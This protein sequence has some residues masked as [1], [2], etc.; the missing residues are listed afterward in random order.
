M[1]F[2]RT[3]GEMS[4]PMLAPSE[5]RRGLVLGGFIV[6]TAGLLWIPQLTSDLW[7]DETGTYWMIKGGIARAFDLGARYQNAQP[8]FYVVEWLDRVLIGSSEAAL[9]MP[10]LLAAIATAALVFALGRR[11]FDRE[12]GLLAA[13]AFV[14][15]RQIAFAAGDARPY[16]LAILAVVASILFLDRWI[17]RRSIRDAIGFLVA[18]SIMLHLHYLYAVILPIHAGY[19]LLRGVK[20][21]NL[22]VGTI[23]LAILFLPAVPGFIF[24]ASRRNTLASPVSAQLDALVLV[25]L[26]IAI[27]VAAVV[28]LRSDSVSDP[29]IRSGWI[30]VSVW[31]LLPPLVLLIVSRTTS[32]YLYEARYAA[33]SLPG[34]ALLI[35]YGFRLITKPAIRFLAACLILITSLVTY[36]FN[37]DHWVEPWSKVQM[38]VNTIAESQ[39]VVLVRTG[40]VE[41]SQIDWLQGGER[42]DYVSA[43]LSY[44]PFRGSVV[45][46]PYRVEEASLEYLEATAASVGSSPHVIVVESNL[47]EFTEWFTNRLESSGFQLDSS[48]PYGVIWVTQ[49]RREG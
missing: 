19:A 4:R 37:S 44:Y 30:L 29:R 33:S 11:M 7:T 25:P 8:L 1:K 31:A 24:L 5:E 15:L 47:H 14:S 35:G 20:K 28:R 27:V 36:G 40:F 3:R 12:T 17:D 48:V 38:V 22:V 41:A 13:A 9:R 45:L 21:G 18:T 39:T 6:G 46:L 49:F 10:S 23:A 2:R 42:S 34:L 32:T 16:S 43:P 26:A